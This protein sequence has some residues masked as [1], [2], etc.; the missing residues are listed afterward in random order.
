MGLP[1]EFSGK[2]PLSA[3]LPKLIERKPELAGGHP[4]PREGLLDEV[5]TEENS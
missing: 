3:G 5:N 2:K 1:L 4:T